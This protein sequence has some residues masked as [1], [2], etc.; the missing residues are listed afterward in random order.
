MGKK[1]PSS[2][3]D[4]KSDP[5]QPSADNGDKRWTLFFWIGVVLSFAL[6]VGRALVLLRIYTVWDDAYIFL[7]YADNLMASGHVAWNPGA[8]P[9]YG[10]TSMLYLTVVV[11]MR[12]LIPHNPTLAVVLSSFT[13]GLIFLIMLIAV[14]HR[15]VGDT[16]LGKILIL[17]VL[18]SLVRANEN[19]MI[20]FMSGMDT[21]FALA[22]LTLYLGVL[23]WQERSA[24]PRAAIVMGLWGGLAFWVRPD[25]CLFTGLT[26]A[27]MFLLNPAPKPRRRALLILGLTVALTLLLVLVSF[28]YLGSPLPLPFYCKGLDR[29][30]PEIEAR[31]QHIPLQELLTFVGNYWHFFLAIGASLALTP[32]A[33]LARTSAAATG[34]LAATGL[35]LAYYLFFVLQIMYFHARFYYP[36]LPALIILALCSLQHLQRS[37]EAKDLVVAQ[38]PASVWKAVLVVMFGSLIGPAINIVKDFSADTVI[39]YKDFSETAATDRWAWLHMMRDQPE[40]VN[41]AWFQLAQISALPDD[42][43]IATT[44]IGHVAAMNPHKTVVDLSGLNDTALAHHGFDPEALLRQY[45][46]D[47]IYMPHSHYIQMNQQ[48]E[49]SPAFKDNYYFVPKDVIHRDWGVA[50]RRDSKYLKQMQDIISAG[51]TTTKIVW[52]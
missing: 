36:A 21:T 20:H 16:V 43:V 15:E 3:P 30:G 14:L 52:E 35:F 31:Y 50:L 5:R 33:W 18:F 29:Y 22:Y 32:K 37:W 12:W 9:T 40:L 44:E 23:F 51:V 28:L 4:R 6:V 17:L 27:A 49:N 10:L 47:F 34:L 1:K 42:L 48:L 25:L 38:V 26:P 39:G 7:R 2:P 41:N 19:L 24:S 8:E 13:S 46:P 11:P 45:H